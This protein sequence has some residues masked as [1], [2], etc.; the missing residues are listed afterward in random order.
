MNGG[1][2]AE[3]GYDRLVKLLGNY[4]TFD[5]TFLP[6]PPAAAVNKAVNVAENLGDLMV[7][8]QKLELEEK[9]LELKKMNPHENAES[10]ATENN[11][12][13]NEE[14]DAEST[15][16]ENNAN[17]NEDS[18]AESTATENN[19]NE[20]E[21]SDAESTATES[22][23]SDTKVQKGGILFTKKECSFF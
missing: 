11:A 13:E 12:N 19:A 4:P 10:T 21:D 17:E 23:A 16:T 14:S 7:E 18:D 20:N 6:L 22:S 15:A 3:N 2:S 1:E 5:L 9:K 8:Q